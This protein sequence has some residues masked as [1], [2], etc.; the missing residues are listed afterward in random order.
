MTMTVTI[1]SSAN[2]KAWPKPKPNYQCRGAQR[3]RDVGQ[4]QGGTIGQVLG[5][6]SRFLS[7]PDQRDDLAQIGLVARLVKFEGHGTLA[8]NGPANRFLALDLIDETRLSGQ[9]RF[10]KARSAL[11]DDAVC[12]DPL[13]GLYQHAIAGFQLCNGDFFRSIIR[14]QAVRG[15]GQQLNQFFQSTRSPDY[16]LH[17]DPMSKEHDIDESDQLPEKHLAGE[18]EHDGARIDE[19]HRDRDADERHHSGAATRHFADEPGKEWPAA[20]DKYDSGEPEEHIAVAGEGHDPTQTEKVLDQ[21]RKRKNGNCQYQRNPKPSAEIRYHRCVVVPGVA[22]SQKIMPQ[23][24]VN[25]VLPDSLF[26]SGST[27]LVGRCLMTMDTVR[28][29][30]RLWCWLS[31]HS[32]VPCSAQRQLDRGDSTLPAR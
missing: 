18:T 7:L 4:P 13:A 8:V 26:A 9:H 14:F 20:I 22:V 6:R 11:H 24:F 30:C 21:R 32:S 28:A 2:S 19:C 5:L 29:L 15:C 1:R 31:I 17:L 10:V 25:H 3:Q 27:R 16:R 23:M 12:R